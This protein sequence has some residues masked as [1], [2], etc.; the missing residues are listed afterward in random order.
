MIFRNFPFVLAVNLVVV[1]PWLTLGLPMYFL[2]AG[3]RL[4]VLVGLF[5]GTFF[6]AFGL[7]LIYVTNAT[8]YFQAIGKQPA[9]PTAKLNPA[10]SRSWGDQAMRSWS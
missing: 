2:E 3:S 9:D 1:A 8:M 10:Q 6:M 4:R 5:G 7:P